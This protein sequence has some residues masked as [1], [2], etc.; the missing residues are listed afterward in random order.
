MTG[1]F[2]NAAVAFLSALL[3]AGCASS[4]QA[5]EP[6]PLRSPAS[7]FRTRADAD[8]ARL[9]GWAGS[10]S[11][12]L[13]R[14]EA[15]PG[16]F[17]EK[18]AQWTLDDARELRQLWRGVL[19]H[20]YALDGMRRFWREDRILDGLGQQEKAEAFALSHAA[21]VTLYA[22]GLRWIE[23]SRGRARLE[24]LLDEPDDEQGT[25]A[26]AFAKLKLGLLHVATMTRF[27]LD[28]RRFRRQ[29]GG[30]GDAWLKTWPAAEGDRVHA[31]LKRRGLQDLIG[32][33]K[34]IVDDAVFKAW[35]PVQKTVA[36]FM[37][38]T[39]VK[40]HGINLV[41]VE[42]AREM[43]ARMRPG[44]L[45]V[46]RRNW[47]LSNVG[48]PGFWPHA[49]LY[50]GTAADLARDFDADEAT[51]AWLAGLPGKPAT[52]AAAL[53]AQAPR[54]WK[55]YGL[56]DAEGNP[57][58]VIEAVGDGVLFNTVEES[59]CGD[60]VAALRPRLRQV[61]KARALL[62]AFRNFAKPYD[63]NFDFVTDSCLVC[64]EL[65]WKCYLPGEG[66]K[67]LVI[68]LAEICGRRTLPPNDIIR[69]FDREGDAPERQFD[70]V[71]FLDGLEKTKGAVVRDAVALRA[72]W[73]RPK[74]DIA[75]Q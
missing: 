17:A 40:R 74:W 71:Y 48:L 66:K 6:L 26:R 69:L 68:P 28:D 46:E 30:L 64:S 35:M 4:A 56:K 65:F 15:R 44:D 8:K 25:P 72:S 43:A 61:D 29:A 2:R 38:D 55:A 50:L 23:L 7:S 32:N 5:P 18:P 45:I 3:L 9:Q 58:R 37:G 60:Y 73:K 63:Y 10:L 36:E 41:A 27:T 16:L 67:G 31:I 12:L 57:L 34:D 14:A 70:F 42:Q 62:E 11:S 47:Y 19:D 59:C 52:L 33:G 53:E 49:A 75:Q 22:E 54:A 39:R 20:V 24:S 13:D 51:R 1:P 21:S